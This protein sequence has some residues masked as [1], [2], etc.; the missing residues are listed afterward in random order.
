[1]AELVLGGVM[2]RCMEPDALGAVVQSA[3]TRPG[4]RFTRFFDEAAFDAARQRTS[5]T[6]VLDE[7]AA[8]ALCDCV[9]QA[10][11]SFG[12]LDVEAR[13]ADE[14]PARFLELTTIALDDERAAQKL[15]DGGVLDRLGAGRHFF[16]SLP[17]RVI[18][19]QF[20]AQTKEA[21]RRL[22][23]GGWDEDLLNLLESAALRARQSPEDLLV[24]VPT[25]REVVGEAETPEPVLEPRPAAPEVGLLAWLERARDDHA[26]DLSLIVGQPLMLQGPSGR[27]VE[28][29]PLRAADVERVLALTLDA[30]HRERFERERAIVS[31]FAVEGLGR[32]R[33]TALVERGVP[34]LSVRTHFVRPD[35]SGLSLPPEL[36]G[37]LAKVARG[38]IVI[39]APAGHGRS[40]LQT[41]L[42]QERART[43]DEVVS[44]EEPIAWPSRTGPVRQLEL[45]DDV[46]LPSFAPIVRT[47]PRAVVGL[48]LVDDVASAH[49]GLELAS[50]GHLVFVTQRALSAAAVIHKLASLDEP[51]GRRRLSESLAA[52]LSLRLIPPSSGTQGPP[53]SP[54]RFVHAVELLLPSEGLRRHLRANDTPAP[55]VLL[56]TEGLTLDDRLLGA[57][58]RQ[59]LTRDEAARWM[60]D[61]RRLDE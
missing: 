45:H 49:L 21:A 25:W 17:V 48:D 37:P 46:G 15:L 7:E 6:G 54:G 18:A 53:S 9:L 16:G 57:V 47:L 30:S 22:L 51:R 43:G 10:G 11:V 28:G 5:H 23:R 50:E 31:S 36:L 14:F 34:S 39:A 44:L 38:L 42:L 52:V 40:T 60:V 12:G 3:E 33:L 4:R 55:P 59:E 56:E 35:V 8:C 1:M 58:R 2:A 24:L 20:T 27:K 13:E 26:T 61:P 29:P 19:R 41:A 32:F